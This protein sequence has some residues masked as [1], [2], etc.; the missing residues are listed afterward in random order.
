M[1][2][3]GVVNS[4]STGM[5]GGG[6]P[7]RK[8]C[9]G[10]EGSRQAA[11][12][13]IVRCCVCGGGGGLWGE[14]EGYGGPGFAGV[15]RSFLK[16]YSTGLERVRWNVEEIKS[17][18]LRRSE[19]KMVA[20]ALE[21]DGRVVLAFTEIPLPRSLVSFFLWKNTTYCTHNFICDF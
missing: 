8:R 1:H 3:R 9:R 20:G 11:P 2:Q 16:A 15:N 14:G 7:R 12:R 10:R 18:N 4:P 19:E 21:E 6:P 13:R 17:K 5:E